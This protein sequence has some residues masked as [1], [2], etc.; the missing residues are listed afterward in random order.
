MARKNLIELQFNDS[1]ILNFGKYLY[2][3]DNLRSK[4]EDTE[5]IT[6]FGSF[7]KDNYFQFHDKYRLK[8]KVVKSS[9][10]DRIYKNDIFYYRVFKKEAN[11]KFKSDNKSDF[12]FDY[13]RSKNKFTDTIDKL[14][15][16]LSKYYY[17]ISDVAKWES[18]IDLSNLYKDSKYLICNSEEFFNVPYEAMSKFNIGS[19][20]CT[21]KP[22]LIISLNN[23][24][25]VN[26]MIKTVKY[27]FEKDSQGI[28][29]FD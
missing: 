6:T 22:I 28:V 4:V 12:Y 20:R 7:P 2:I 5:N 13:L 9:P 21:I 11:S 3:L 18:D 10:R 15:S 23:E 29:I 16:N 25:F 27:V 14:I 26:E 1:D 8:L 24:I 19:L 17:I